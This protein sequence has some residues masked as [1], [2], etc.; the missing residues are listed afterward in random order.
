MIVS[1]VERHMIK[2]S[3]KMWRVCDELCFES[4]NLYNYANYIQRQKFIKGERII[5]YND[6]SQLLNK[7]ETF[8]SLGSNSSQHTLKMLDKVWK[9]FFIA[10]KDY[11]K[12]PS[13]YLGRPKLPTYKDKNG[14]YVCVL[15]NLQSQIKDGYLYFAFK[16]LQ[17]FNNIFRT[18][19]KGKHMQTRIIP[20]GSCYVLEVVYET[21]VPEV[22]KESKNIVGIDLG[23]N[24]LITSYDPLNNKSFIVNGRPLKSI[25][26]YYNKR[27][28]SLMSCIGDK[29]TSNRIRRMTLK[30]ECKI[31]DYMHKSSRFVINY[32]IKNQI[33]N[34]VIGNNKDWKQECNMGKRNNQNFVSIPFE[35]I[36]SMMQ[37][38]AEEYG[39]NV[40][41][42]E[43]SY[44]SK[45]DHFAGEEMC[46]HEHYLG[47]RVKRGLFKS[48]T[49]KIVNADTNGAIGILRKV[50]DEKFKHLIVSRGNV[51]S[52]IRLNV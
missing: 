37:Y 43:E 51:V 30:R 49:G 34:I 25:N 33:A 27:K 16:P 21:E 12:Y 3:H 15:T 52:P 48:S 28:A 19:I 24:N 29:G 46:K 31:N 10:I 13:K 8:T 20:K 5:K 40:I 50:A 41:I 36:I 6:L 1:R 22:L 17:P 9:S 42:T 11:S 32:C 44:T 7:H 2:K 26:Q 14:R 39:I 38:K 45:V 18:K 47:K 4:K 35:K 23:L